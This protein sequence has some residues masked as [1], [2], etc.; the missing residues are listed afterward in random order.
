MRRLLLALL[1]IISTGC[2]GAQ[3]APKTKNLFGDDGY[4]Y[5]DEKISYNQYLVTYEG[6]PLN[7]F[8]QQLD[9]V[10][11][12]A[13]EL[14]NSSNYKLEIEEIYDVYMVID[15]NYLSPKTIGLVTCDF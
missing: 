2:S 15:G 4:G 10:T 1:F 13:N 7:N 14:C 8:D 5:S 6:S 12:R 3:Y 9:F 11:K